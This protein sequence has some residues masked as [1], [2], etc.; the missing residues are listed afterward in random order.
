MLSTVT[1]SHITYCLLRE[2]LS[3]PTS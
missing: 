3:R 1:I 2:R